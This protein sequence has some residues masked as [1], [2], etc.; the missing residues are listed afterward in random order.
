MTG[1]ITRSKDVELYIGAERLAGVTDFQA[2]CVSD[3]YP[4]REY[5]SGDAV[6]V[7]NTDHQYEIRL[8]V[9]SPFRLEL[10][11]EQ[12]FSLREMDDRAVFYYEGCA[13]IRH[14]RIVK[15]GKDV[16]DEFLITAKSMRKQ[17]RDNE[18]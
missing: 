8:T 5:L 7:V 2:R 15:A 1:Y 13:V 4:I 18:G 11:D 16:A 17:V 9:L 14:D 3:G 6:A 12:P 10:L